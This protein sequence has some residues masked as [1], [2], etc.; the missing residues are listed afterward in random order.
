MEFIRT[1]QPGINL[2]LLGTWAPGSDYII[3]FVVFSRV[4]HKNIL[5]TSLQL[6]NKVLLNECIT[7]HLKKNKQTK[8]NRTFLRQVQN[9]KY[10]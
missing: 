8:H 3:I 4:L 6:S 10:D 1:L 2:Q 9:A 7:F 5:L